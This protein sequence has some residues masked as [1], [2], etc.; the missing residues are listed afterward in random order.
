MEMLDVLAK[1]RNS[2][3]FKENVPESLEVLRKW[4]RRVERRDVNL[5]DLILTLRISK[6]LEEYTV[7]TIRSL[8]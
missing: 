3:E 7:L 4:I 5:E 8:R 6:S 1:A 2:K